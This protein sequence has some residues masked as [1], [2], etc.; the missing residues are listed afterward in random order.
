LEWTNQ[1]LEKYLR[2]FV[3]HRQDDW[4]KWLPI[5]QYVHNTWP[6]STTK[7]PPFELIIEYVPHAHQAKNTQKTPTLQDCIEHVHITI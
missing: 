3:N 7:A 2:I 5:A 6:S 4:V 1:W